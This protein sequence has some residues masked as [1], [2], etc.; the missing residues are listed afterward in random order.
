MPI[1]GVNDLSVTTGTPLTISNA[2][3]IRFQGPQATYTP[4]AGDTVNEA[5]FFGRAD[6][7]DIG[8][9]GLMVVATGEVI[10]KT[11]VAPV[12]SVSEYKWHAAAKSF[13]LAPYVGKELAL[14]QVFRNAEDTGAAYFST[15]NIPDT[16]TAINPRS[17]SPTV[18]ATI[19]DSYN[20]N[21]NA[22]YRGVP[23]YFNVVNV[24]TGPTLSGKL[25]RRNG[26][27]VIDTSGLVI[28]VSTAQGGASIIPASTISTNATGDWTFTNPDALAYATQYWVT[29]AKAD[30]SETFVGK[31]ST[32]SDPGV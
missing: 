18:L 8:H 15:H 24:P 10:Y 9:L 20:G 14:L 23:A 25:K 5:G 16:A 26:V 21:W 31:L 6:P 13:D 4:V 1:I 17:S 29:I 3:L 2:R 27:P 28:T 11:T 30:G 12:D 19:P 22:D 7:A 32:Q